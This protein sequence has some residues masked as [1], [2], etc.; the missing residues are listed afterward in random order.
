[1]KYKTHKRHNLQIL[2][3]GSQKMT[4]FDKLLFWDTLQMQYSIVN[5]NNKN[6]GYTIYITPKK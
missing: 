2:D 5:R 6:S 1:M 4:M 3:N